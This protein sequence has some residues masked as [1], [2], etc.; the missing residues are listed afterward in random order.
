MD[1][2]FLA[3][4]VVL[5]LIASCMPAFG[6]K[7]DDGIEGVKAERNIVKSCLNQLIR[8]DFPSKGVLN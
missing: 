3:I 5:A 8:L 2:S 7:D 6:A 1:K 4:F